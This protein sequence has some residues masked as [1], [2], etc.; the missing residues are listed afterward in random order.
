MRSSI[1]R[2]IVAVTV[3][4]LLCSCGGDEH[5]DNSATMPVDDSYAYSSYYSSSDWTPSDT[6][7]TDTAKAAT[8]I[9]VNIP[10][11]KYSRWY[12]EGYEQGYNNGSLTGGEPGE[13]TYDDYY[14][15][16]GSCPYKSGKKRK[17]YMRGYRD[18]F[19]DGYFDNCDYDEW[20]NY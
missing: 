1:P 20:G 6:P 3:A 14:E 8:G 2:Y 7:R 17:E 16:D 18:G 10:E 12:N 15:Y 11:E 5:V 9:K 13:G 19:H 4:M